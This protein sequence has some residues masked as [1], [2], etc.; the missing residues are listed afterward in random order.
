MKSLPAA[1]NLRPSRNYGSLMDAKRGRRM[2][3]RS[4]S[5]TTAID[6]SPTQTTEESSAPDMQGLL[7]RLSVLARALEHHM[8]GYLSKQSTSISK[9]WN[10]RWFVLKEYVLTYYK[11]RGDT[12]PSGTIPTMGREVLQSD[13]CAHI[14][15]LVHHHLL[16]VLC[17]L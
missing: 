2:H 15:R 8:L 12:T 1:A 10:K 4:V 11:D 13:A 16:G 3:T 9:G 5:M 7:L 14:P 6:F 17:D